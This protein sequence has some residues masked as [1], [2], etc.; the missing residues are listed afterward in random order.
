MLGTMRAK[1]IPVDAVA[2]DFD[3]PEQLQNFQWNSRW[4]GDS[5]AKL[6]E[7]G[8]N[9]VKFLLSQSGPMIRRSSSNYQDG[10]NHGIFATDGKGQP[11]TCG[12]YGGDLM[13]FT[14]HNMKDWLWPQISHL[15]EEG[16]K[17][18]WLDLT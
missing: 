11:V 4:N 16:I 13:D 3:W 15:H 5:P 12:Y 8:G 18:W 10:L 17:G 9:G 7:H 6:R 2:L 14:A 1:N